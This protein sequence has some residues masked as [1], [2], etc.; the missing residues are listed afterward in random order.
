MN[1][2]RPDF[3]RLDRDFQIIDR[4]GGRCEMENIVQIARNVDEFRDVVVIELEVGQVEQV[5]DVANVARNEVVHR[6]DVVA[7]FDKPIAE[8]RPQET[9]P[10]CNEYAFHK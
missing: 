6:N 7:L 9:S 5:F 1:A 2:Q 3:Q 4:A 10:A 8:V